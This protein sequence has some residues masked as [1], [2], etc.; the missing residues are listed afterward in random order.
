MNSTERNDLAHAFVTALERGMYPAWPKTD[1]E[2]RGLRAQLRKLCRENEQLRFPAYPD[3]ARI[4]GK[5]GVAP[6]ATLQGA[7]S[8]VYRTI[9]GLFALHPSTNPKGSL[10]ATCRKL[11]KGREEAFDRHFRRLLACRDLDDGCEIVSRLVRRA[12]AADEPVDYRR[13]FADLA[14][15]RWREDVLTQWSADYV[16]APPKPD[17]ADVQPLPSDA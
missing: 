7:L 1:P 14:R 13:L 6:D 2:K 11:A 12:K 5:A 3:L 15:W 8:P 17:A 16:G 9:A 10:G 4:A